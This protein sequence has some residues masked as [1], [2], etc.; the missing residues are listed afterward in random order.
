MARSRH[1][2]TFDDFSGPMVKPFATT[3]AIP[4]AAGRRRLPPNAFVQVQNMVPDAVTNI[5]R[6]RGGFY[7][8]HTS[9]APVGC[10]GIARADSISAGLK[11]YYF[12]T[13]GSVYTIDGSIPPTGFSFTSIAA[14]ASHVGSITDLADFTGTLYV[15]DGGPLNKIATVTDTWTGNIAGTPANVERL[16]VFNNRLWGVFRNV[17]YFS[18]LGNGDTLG[19]T[20]AGGGSFT[21]PQRATTIVA[22]REWLLVFHPR[23]IG[24]MTGWG[25]A[26]FQYLDGRRGVNAGFGLG[27]EATFWTKPVQF[28]D[29]LYWHTHEGPHILARMSGMDIVRVESPLNNVFALGI[30][31]PVFVPFPG[32]NPGMLLISS[33]SEQNQLLYFPKTGRFADFRP[34]TA[35]YPDFSLLFGFATVVTAES[36]GTQ[37]WVWENLP[38]L[39][40]A[41]DAAGTDKTGGTAQVSTLRTGVLSSPPHMVTTARRLRVRY[42]A[43]Q[44]ITINL[45]ADATTVASLTLPDT[46]GVT[47]EEEVVLHAWGRGR[48]WQLEF[49]T[50]VAAADWAISEA[51]LEVFELGERAAMSAPA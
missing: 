26:D 33:E 38:E 24:L 2:L 42:S 17:L 22:Y 9:A 3:Q 36:G 16:A 4:A 15:A 31:S 5:W 10:A 14:A 50:S 47:A 40:S 35:H 7:K 6:P 11:Y 19:N 34:S 29:A 13:N 8:G 20:S 18:S 43:A 32:A 25:Q 48:H 39:A 27:A 44:A 21:L 49:T 23:E 51:A 12:G 46:G 41:G 37:L 30:V 1:V 45:I 28:D